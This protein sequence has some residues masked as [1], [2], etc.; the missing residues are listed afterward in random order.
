M[1]EGEGGGG[2]ADE[3]GGGKESGRE[4]GKEGGRETHPM[5][6]C[7][8]TSKVGSPDDTAGAPQTL[9]PTPGE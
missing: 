9:T 4:R 8:E 3:T 2:R 1:R 6:S 7:E 5:Q